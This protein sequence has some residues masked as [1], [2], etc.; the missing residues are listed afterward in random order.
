MPRI[1]CLSLGLVIALANAPAAAQNAATDASNLRTITGLV[2]A[3]TTS[4]LI[5]D[6]DGTNIPCAIVASTRYIGRGHSSDGVL[7]TPRPTIVDIIKPGDRVTVSYRQSATSNI[8]VDV[9]FYRPSRP[10]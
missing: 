9:R 7:R 3:V 10:R 8:A 6:R 1:A 4:E 2:K 5:V